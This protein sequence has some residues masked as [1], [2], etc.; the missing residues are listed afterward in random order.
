MSGRTELPRYWRVFSVRARAEKRV[1]ERLAAAGI[2]T[3]LPLRVA[4]RQWSDR[5]KR[6]EV[7]LFPGYVFAHVDERE[8]LAALTDEAVARAVSFG[9]TP[10]VVSDREMDLV[11]ALAAMPER[12]EA[13]TRE[14]FPVG[15]EVILTNGPLQGARGHVT[16]HPREAYLLVEVPSVRQ[17]IRVHVPA[18][19]AFRPV[20]ADAHGRRA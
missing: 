13:V 1:A 14:A 11:R 17:S 19:W 8:R 7:P 2:E 4:L 9:G 16:G 15:A 20:A 5:K 12:V 3:F 18:N 6:V 10:A